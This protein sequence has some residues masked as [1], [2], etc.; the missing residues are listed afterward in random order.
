M[1]LSEQ[2][3]Y[4]RCSQYHLVIGTHD[5]AGHALLSTSQLVIDVVNVNDH[6]PQFSHSEYQVFLPEDCDVGSFVI[7]LSATDG[8]SCHGNLTL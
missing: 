3:D 5:A 6:A 7:Q 2:L 8:D 1:T 4:E